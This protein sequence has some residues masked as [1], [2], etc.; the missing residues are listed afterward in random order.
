MRPPS[1]RAICIRLMVINGWFGCHEV[2][3]WESGLPP[4]RSREL[5]NKKLISIVGFDICETVRMKT[6][7]PRR[8]FVIL[9]QQPPANKRAHTH[10]HKTKKK[11]DPF[12]IAILALVWPSGEALSHCMGSVPMDLSHARPLS[13]GT[14]MRS[15]I[16]LSSSATNCFAKEEILFYIMQKQLWKW[17]CFHCFF[18]AAFGETV[19]WL[20][21]L[22]LETRVKSL[23][24]ALTQQTNKQVFFSYKAGC[25]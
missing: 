11:N 25:V 13:G 15:F 24:L 23:S 21:R 9:K 2:H 8:C 20:Q 6:R 5:K 3:Q 19:G 17:R 12:R 16:Q 10:T 14:P 18:A 7:G 1:L 4:L 22:K